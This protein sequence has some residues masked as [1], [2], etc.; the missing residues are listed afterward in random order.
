MSACISWILIFGYYIINKPEMLIA[1][2]LFGI[3]AEVSC[4]KRLKE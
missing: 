1:A 2:G 4:L 3:A